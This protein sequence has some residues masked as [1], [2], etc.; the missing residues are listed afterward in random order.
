MEVF[1]QFAGA[2]K[3]TIFELQVGTRP[4][5]LTHIQYSILEYLYF[6]GD[7]GLSEISACM[8]LAMPNASREVKKLSEKGYVVK[9]NDPIDKRKSTIQVSATGRTLMEK[10]FSKIAINTNKHL[11]DLSEEEQDQFIKHMDIMIN[12]IF[13]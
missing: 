3:K 6:S 1:F 11:S 13:K 9:I 12:R 5:E 10:T 4:E 2:T 8:Y 7:K